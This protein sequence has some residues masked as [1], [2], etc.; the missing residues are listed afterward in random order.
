MKIVE[1]SNPKSISPHQIKAKYC[2]SFLGKFKGLMF[3]TSISSDLGLLLVENGNS[4][5]NTSIHMLFMF[6]DITAVWINSENIIVDVKLAKKWFPFYFPRKPAQYVL[7]C[8][9]S[10][11]N[12]FKI[13]DTVLIKDV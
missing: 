4:K 1:I 8:H 11:I 13:G 5:I 7:E 2:N 10:C 3:D 6:F 12:Y 9:T